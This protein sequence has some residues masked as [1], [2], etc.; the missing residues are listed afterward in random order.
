MN[1]KLLNQL[2]I[3]TLFVRSFGQVQGLGNGQPEAYRC[4][5]RIARQAYNAV[6]VKKNHKKEKPQISS[7]IQAKNKKMRNKANLSSQKLTAT[8]CSIGTYNDLHPKSQKGAK[9][10]N[11]ITNA[12]TARFPITK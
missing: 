6:I 3:L 8:T 10:I 12:H 4:T 5:L 1:T 9:P 7:D 2:N 11:P